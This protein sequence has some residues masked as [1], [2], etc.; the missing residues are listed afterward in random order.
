MVAAFLVEMK[1]FVQ[2]YVSQVLRTV[3]FAA[4]LVALIGSAANIKGKIYVYVFFFFFFVWRLNDVSKR[5]GE[6]EFRFFFFA[7]ELSGEEIIIIT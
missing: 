1:S 4:M 2:N 5:M 6:T 7:A 3:L